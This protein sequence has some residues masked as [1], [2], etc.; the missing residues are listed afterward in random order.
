VQDGHDPQLE[1]AV[2]IAMEQMEKNS[3]PVPHRP[4]FPNYQNPNQ[5]PASVTSGSGGRP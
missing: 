5:R 2:S 4:A 3:A 1:R